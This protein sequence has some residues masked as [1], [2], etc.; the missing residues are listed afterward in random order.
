MNITTFNVGLISGVAV[1]LEFVSA[2]TAGVFTVIIDLGIFRVLIQ[3]GPEEDF[4][5]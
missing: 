3:H 2:E 5:D 1:G 4:E